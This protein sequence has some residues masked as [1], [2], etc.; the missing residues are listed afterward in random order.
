MKGGKGGRGIRE[1]RLAIARAH[2]S[3]HTIITHAHIRTHERRERDEFAI[4][5]ARLFPFVFFLFSSIEKHSRPF[6][7]VRFTGFFDVKGGRKTNQR[8]RDIYLVNFPDFVRSTSQNLTNDNQM[9]R[10]GK[11]W[12]RVIVIAARFRSIIAGDN[13]LH[14]N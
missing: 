13:F 4:V 3:I 5:H 1:G 7:E 9:E 6:H 11:I 10:Y 2:M 8:K 14:L 12:K